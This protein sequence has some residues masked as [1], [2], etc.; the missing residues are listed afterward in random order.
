MIREGAF[1]RP[2]INTAVRRVVA[3][4]VT[5]L[6]RCPTPRL[7]DSYIGAIVYERE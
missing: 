7:V 4:R 3:R 6:C 5:F 1:A 2:L